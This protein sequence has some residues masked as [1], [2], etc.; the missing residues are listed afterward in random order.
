MDKG[1]KRMRKLLTSPLLMVFISLVVLSGFTLAQAAHQRKAM[2]FQIRTQ[3]DQIQSL[4]HVQEFDDTSEVALHLSMRSFQSDSGGNIH[5]VTIVYDQDGQ[6]V[7]TETAGRNKKRLERLQKQLEESAKN[8][9]GIWRYMAW[10]GTNNIFEIKYY[11][12]YRRNPDG[13]YSSGSGSTHWPA[14]DDK[15]IKS[16]HVFAAEAFP[17]LIAMRQLLPAYFLVTLLL[18]ALVMSHKKAASSHLSR[19]K[20]LADLSQE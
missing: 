9:E 1:G 18:I 4:T 20:N 10:S 8:E 7:A 19:K 15:G 11:E 3:N 12:T 5:A 2:D 14:D 13:T 16:F 17:L 6:L